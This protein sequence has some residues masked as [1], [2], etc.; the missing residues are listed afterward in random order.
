MAV[1]ALKKFVNKSDFATIRVPQRVWPCPGSVSCKANWC[2]IC[3]SLYLSS[4]NT[5]LPKRS[6]ERS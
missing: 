3:G 4:K 2:K 5:S 6:A 1:R